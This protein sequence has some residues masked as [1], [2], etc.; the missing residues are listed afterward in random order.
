MQLALRS[1]LF[2]IDTIHPGCLAFFL[3]YWFPNKPARITPTSKKKDTR[4][5]LAEIKRNNFRGIY[6]VCWLFITRSKSVQFRGITKTNHINYNVLSQERRPVRMT[7][8][9]ILTVPGLQLILTMT[10][11]KITDVTGKQIKI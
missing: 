1:S 4:D 10:T 2:R 3:N 8:C 7:Y 11:E 6:K 5:S 9:Q